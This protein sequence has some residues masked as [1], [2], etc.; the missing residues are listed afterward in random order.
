MNASPLQVVGIVVL[1]TGLIGSFV[2]WWRVL[3]G[4]ALVLESQSPPDSLSE[5]EEPP[6]LPP[7]FEVAFGPQSADPPRVSGLV[8]FGSVAI[9]LLSQILVHALVFP[10]DDASHDAKRTTTSD[11]ETAS[12]RSAGIA[13]ASSADAHAAA[14][15]LASKPPEER[16][17][18]LCGSQLA[19]LLLV[20]WLLTE[21][22]RRTLA[23]YGIALA[24]WLAALRRGVFG[25]LVAIAPVVLVLIAS[26][27]WRSVEKQNPLLQWLR[28]NPSPLLVGGIVLSATVLAPLVEELLFRVLA[29][30]WLRQWMRPSRAIAVSSAAFALI[31]GWP[32]S[33]A[34]VPLAVVLGQAYERTRSYLTVVTIHATFNVFFLVLAVTLGSEPEP[35]ETPIGT[36]ATVRADDGR[37]VG[38]GAAVG[39]RLQSGGRVGILACFDRGGEPGSARSAGRSAQRRTDM[40]NAAQLVASARPELGTANCRRLRRA[41]RIPGNVYGHGQDP[42]AISV[43][44]GDLN[45]AVKAGHKVVDLNLDGAVEKAMF[46]DVQWD[47][48]GTNIEHFDLLRVSV[49]ER[50]HVEGPVELKGTAPGTLSGGIL[51]QPLRTLHVECLALSIPDQ[52]VVKIGELGLGQA[53]H[54]KEVEVP[55]GVKVLNPPDA[56]VVHVVTAKAAAEPE[57]GEAGPAEPEVIGKK[58][59]EAAEEK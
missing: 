58:E 15:S 25:F 52:I 59:K 29:Q 22:G 30:G 19:T 37:A 47:F 48:L 24:D 2:A 57:A 55:E 36:A 20:P 10:P 39:V 27:P 38:S 28:Q 44:V 3:R 56:V 50:V 13:A 18:A 53:I 49:D 23:E 4:M 40:V 45:A 54:V 43:S 17:L 34:L 11:V 1:A 33:V 46:R 51:D 5:A 31:H 32:D 7:V 35:W 26:N 16:L 42:T 9:W 12:E 6:A 14:D 21:G 41:G 8:L